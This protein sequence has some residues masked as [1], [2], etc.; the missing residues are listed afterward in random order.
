MT[1]FHLML[2]ASADTAEGAS[3]HVVN[4]WKE[5]AFICAHL[6]IV[7]S[8]GI[9]FPFWEVSL[10]V[11]LSQGTFTHAETKKRMLFQ[12]HAVHRIHGARSVPCTDSALM[13]IKHAHA[14]WKCMVSIF[15]TFLKWCKLKW[16]YTSM[17]SMMQDGIAVQSWKW[18]L[19]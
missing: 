8:V 14:D 15:Y 7:R 11:F 19:Q 1:W 9:V 16:F 12:G 18:N 10:S 5:M 3:C 4:M 17:I 2:N 13:L 6:E